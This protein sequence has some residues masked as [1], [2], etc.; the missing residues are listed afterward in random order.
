MILDKG[1]KYNV[2]KDEILNN[3]LNE[4]GY[5]V[6]HFLSQAEIQDLVSFFECGTDEQKNGFTTFAVDDYE[7][8]KSVNEKIIE[9]FSRGFSKFFSGYIPFWGNFFTKQP[10]SPAMPLHADLQ[11]VEEPEQ[12]SLNVWCPLVDTLVENGAFGVV[13]FSHKYVNQIRGMNIT[14]LYRKYAKEIEVKLGKIL[15]IKA[16]YAVIY[17]HRLLHYSLPN[18]STEKRLAATLVA[19]PE[20]TSLIHYYA[21]KEGDTLVYKYNI[22]SVED[23]LHTEFLKAPKGKHPVAK[24]LFEASPL[25]ASDFA[26][27]A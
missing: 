24:N 21:N 27:S 5:V 3:I 22:D 16:G 15:E 11:Y 25:T 12:I 26:T 20:G 23:F 6:V 1:K 7:Y 4:E 8:R 13:P 2:F 18:N 10:G 17:D 19:V 14:D 9:I